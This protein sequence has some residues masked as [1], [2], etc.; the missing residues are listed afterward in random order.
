M[1]SI[2]LNLALAAGLLMALANAPAMAQTTAPYPSKPVRI[3]VGY[4]AGGPTDLVARLLASKLQAALGQPVIVENKPGAGSNIASEAVALASPDGYTLMVAAAPI[5][6]NGFLYKNLKFDVQK[7]FEPISMLMSAPVVL[8]VN[9]G[10]PAKNLSELIAL[11]KKQPGALTFASSSTGGTV[12]L[13]GEM[14]KQRAGIDILHV[15]YKGASS[16]LNDL[17]AGHVTMAFMTS[18]SH[19]P[20][21]K[22]GNPRPIAVASAKRLPQL[23]D[24]PTMAEAGMPGFEVDSWNGLFAPAGTPSD[25]IARLQRETA[26]AVASPE[27]REKLYAQGAVPVGGT[28]AEFREHIK[29]EVNH[30][31]QFLK[32]VKVSMD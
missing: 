3:I 16:A 21:L 9:P 14:F 11:A 6:M 27:V 31:S 18:V 32:T 22:A 19:V 2:K 10:T 29:K 23:P 25:I 20:H 17:V 7:S 28:S 30:W 15:P 26:K 12:H 8:G 24:V 5:T 13:A 1:Q 4:Q